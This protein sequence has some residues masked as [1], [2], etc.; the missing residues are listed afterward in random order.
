[1]PKPPSSFRWIAGVALLWNL[2]GLVAVVGDLRLSAADI[3]ALP[4]AKQAL[5][6]A[7]P[8][9]SVV[10]SVVAVVGGSAG[11]AALLFG[12]RWALPLLWASVAGVFIQDIGL[13]WVASAGRSPE[14]VPVVLQGL[15]L[16]IALALVGFARRGLNKGWLS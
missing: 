9:W 1:L 15:V 5:Y 7:R 16:L 8:L 10:A 11:C 13:F 3:A 4:A 6:A 2:L 12:S 14:V